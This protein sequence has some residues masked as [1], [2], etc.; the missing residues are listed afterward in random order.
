M[1]D[2]LFRLMCF[3]FSPM[4]TLLKFTLGVFIFSLSTACSTIELNSQEQ[5]N[6]VNPGIANSTVAQH[7]P[8]LVEK[9]K[10]K[11]LKSEDTT[12]PTTSQDCEDATILEKPKRLRE[13]KP[14]EHDLNQLKAGEK[15]TSFKLPNLAG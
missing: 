2:F 6:S 14:N 1:I 13:I 15:T 11:Q 3:L 12:L 5:V 7:Q 10:V 9:E 8:N 4:Q